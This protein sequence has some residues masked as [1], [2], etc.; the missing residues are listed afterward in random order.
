MTN[1][2]LAIDYKLRTRVSIFIVHNLPKSGLLVLFYPQQTL[3][4]RAV[5]RI[6]SDPAK[7]KLKYKIN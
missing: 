7:I 5:A 3:S 1:I 6:L 2:T 4:R